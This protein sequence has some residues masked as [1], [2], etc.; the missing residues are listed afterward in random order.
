M[1]AR[2]AFKLPKNL[3]EGIFSQLGSSM[4]ALVRPAPDPSIAARVRGWI[5]SFDA[6]FKDADPR[7]LGCLHAGLWV[8]ADELDR[9]HAICQDIP[10]TCGS[11][12]HAIVHRREPD[13]PNARYWWGRAA[14]IAWKSGNN[15][16]LAAIAGSSLDAAGVPALASWRKNLA[17]SYNPAA[18]VDLVESH[19]A[20]GDPAVIGALSEL[21]RL[22][23]AALFLECYDQLG[24]A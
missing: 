10:T 9:A 19:H 16:S 17:R 12:W 20:S 1:D 21:Q 8:L 15:P 11:A 14:G 5:A 18:F 6:Q 2:D 13:F 7:S 4:T 3:D 24:G 22:E 23:W